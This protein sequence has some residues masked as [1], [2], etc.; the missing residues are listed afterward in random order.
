MDARIILV[1]QHVGNLF[2]FIHVWLTACA[3]ACLL[4]SFANIT[5][6]RVMHTSLSLVASKNAYDA[7]LL[8]ACCHVNGRE[9]AYNR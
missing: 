5:V 4:L 1:V 8:Y 7:A 9:D 6:M 2:P 3:C